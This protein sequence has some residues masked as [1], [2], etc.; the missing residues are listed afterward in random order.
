M[1]K[2]TITGYSE[3]FWVWEQFTISGYRLLRH[4]PF[5]LVPLPLTNCYIKKEIWLCSTYELRLTI[6]SHVKC[7]HRGEYSVNF[8][9]LSLTD[10]CVECGRRYH[11]YKSNLFYIVP[12]L[13]PAIRAIGLYTANFLCYCQLFSF[14]N[15]V[16]YHRLSIKYCT[17]WDVYV[18][19][20][21]ILFDIYSY[22]PS[23]SH[24]PLLHFSWVIQITMSTTDIT[25]DMDLCISSRE[26]VTGLEVTIYDK[27]SAQHVRHRLPYSN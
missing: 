16:P 13:V 24:S 15:N 17:V 2:Q 12:E 4:F 23:A 19:H 3:L 20:T 25:H 5:P 26:P 9:L 7:K 1:P 8:Q 10:I 11:L 27:N 6:K 21:F 18:I 14:E 22:H